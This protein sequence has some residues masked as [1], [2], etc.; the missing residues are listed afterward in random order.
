M[1]LNILCL[2]GDAKSDSSSF[3]GAGWFGIVV[4][5]VVVAESAAAVVSDMDGDDASLVI[6]EGGGDPPDI[7]PLVVLVYGFLLQLFVIVVDGGGGGGCFFHLCAAVVVVVVAVGVGG[8][9]TEA[10]V[11]AGDTVMAA[12]DA[13]EKGD[14]TT[15]VVVGVDA[16]LLGDGGSFRTEEEENRLVPVADCGCSGSD[17]SIVDV[18]LEEEE[19]GCGTTLF[20]CGMA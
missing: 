8:L 7:P 20:F 10:T 5:V 11:V 1:D 19:A 17:D 14:D 16:T 15:A 6:H 9:P 2:D 4:A 18:L 13:T 3:C 12:G